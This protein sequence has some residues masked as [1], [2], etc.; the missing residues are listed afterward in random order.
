MRRAIVL[1][2]AVGLLTSACA[3]VDTQR[4]NSLVVP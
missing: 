3:G 4:A 1:L 2:L